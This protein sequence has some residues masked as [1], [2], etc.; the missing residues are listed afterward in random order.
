M[1]FLPRPRNPL[2]SLNTFFFAQIA[3]FSYFPLEFIDKIF[4]FIEKQKRKRINVNLD[5]KYLI[6]MFFI[7][8]SFD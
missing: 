6:I 7:H 2:Q 1:Q 5:K 8:L 4:E 3:M